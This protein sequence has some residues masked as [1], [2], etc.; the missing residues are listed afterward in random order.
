MERSARGLRWVER[1]DPLQADAARFARH[2]PGDRWFVDET[3]VKVAGVWCYLYRAIDRDGTLVDVYLSETR[4]MAAAKAF[5]RS[6]RSVTQVEPEQVTT[7]GQT[8]YPKAIADEL[9]TRSYEMYSGGEAFRINFAIRVALSQM[10][11]R[12]AG[13]HAGDERWGE[14]EHTHEA[15]DHPQRQRADDEELPEEAEPREQVP[16]FV[17]GHG[18]QDQEPGVVVQRVGRDQEPACDGERDQRAGPAGP[19]GGRADVRITLAEGTVLTGTIDFNTFAIT[20]FVPSGGE[21][22]LRHDSPRPR[23]LGRGVIVTRDGASVIYIDRVS[24]PGT[25]RP[26]CRSSES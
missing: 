17:R 22:D 16:G 18:H 5:L 2:S 20:G 11:A 26:V 3:Y 8:S 19:P 1:L 21:V 14:P 13:A 12:R 9:G 7:D 24:T 6:A 10:L 25:M 4:D 23:D 15:P